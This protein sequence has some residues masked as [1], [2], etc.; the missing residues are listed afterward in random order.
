MN[1]FT[2]TQSRNL[3]EWDENPHNSL[4]RYNVD[5][6]YITDVIEQLDNYIENTICLWYFATLQTFNSET[7]EL[8]STDKWHKAGTPKVKI[9]LNEEARKSKGNNVNSKIAN[10]L[11]EI[12]WANIGKA[13]PQPEQLAPEVDHQYDIE[14]G[15]EH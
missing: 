9:R 14:E 13:V 1:I 15:E 12:E 10:I 5:M 7:G 6:F 11:N 8:V 3:Y 4:V 2:V